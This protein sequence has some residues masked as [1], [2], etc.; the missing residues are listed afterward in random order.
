MQAT[1]HQRSAISHFLFDFA[2][3]TDFYRV[4]RMIQH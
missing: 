2:R 4:K 3:I 1:H